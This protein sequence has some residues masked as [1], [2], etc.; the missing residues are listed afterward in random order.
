MYLKTQA[1]WPLLSIKAL[2]A[3]RAYQQ[4]HDPAAKQR[5]VQRSRL[6]AS[7]VQG[8]KRHV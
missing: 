2:P 6:K 3:Y 1:M 4:S 5:R 7:Y 8:E